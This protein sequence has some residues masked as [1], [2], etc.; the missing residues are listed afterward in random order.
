MSKYYRYTDI[1]RYISVRHALVRVQ[2]YWYDVGAQRIQTRIDKVCVY[3]YS[4]GVCICTYSKLN[5]WLS[6]D[7][8]AFASIGKCWEWLVYVTLWSREDFTFWSSDGAVVGAIQYTHSRYIKC[9]PM[10]VF[11]WQ[12][13]IQSFL[14]EPLYQDITYMYFLE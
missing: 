12:I 1:L 2:S 14:T 9:W 11:V 13:L 3:V 7:C 8:V 5:K 4:D 6:G 10:F